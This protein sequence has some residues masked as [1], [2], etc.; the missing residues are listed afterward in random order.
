M[1]DIKFRGKRKDN[2]E[3]VYGYLGAVEHRACESPAKEL[4]Y[5][6]KDRDSSH[7]VIP[8]TV[9]QFT[10]LHW[11]DDIL[12]STDGLRRFIV[13]YNDKECKWYLK[14]IGKA[15]NIPDP[16][17]PDYK[18]IDDIHSNPELLKPADSPAGPE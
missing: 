2:S 11:E 12:E 3:W 18:H 1:R 5:I 7:F 15:W 10:G 9:G 17:W 4:L 16:I 8:E 14:G 13:A 6:G